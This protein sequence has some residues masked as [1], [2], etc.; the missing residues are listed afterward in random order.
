MSLPVRIA[1]RYSLARG[2]FLSFVTFI[3]AAGLALGTAVLVVVLSVMNGFERELADRVLGALP[4]AVILGRDGVDDWRELATAAREDPR[5]RAA[6]PISRGPALVA[7]GDRVRAVE[8]TGIEPAAEREVSILPGRML[9]GDMDALAAGEFGAVL[10]SR[11][12]AELEVGV[13]DRVTV[14]MPDPRVTLA[15]AFPRQKRMR[16]VGLFELGTELD[17]TGLYVHLADARRLLRIP[18]AAQGVRLRLHDLFQSGAVLRSLLARR[19]DPDLRGIDWRR[20]HGN[21]HEAIG[22]QKRIMFVLLSLLVAVA[23]FNVVAMLTMVVRNRRG[24]IA[25]LRTMG[26]LPGALVRVFFIQGSF[27][28]VAG[29]LAG[30]LLGVGVTLLLPTIAEGLTALLGRDLLAEYFVRELPVAI[31]VPDL[32]GIVLVALAI[33]LLTTWWPAH[34]ALAVDPAEELRHE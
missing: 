28:A 14:V 22:L 25:I 3:A 29:I 20:T 19:G 10:G 1:L 8:L 16:V 30:L 7:A 31:R 32:A 12:A 26:M 33:S 11:L 4:H 6:A 13:G 21:L 23:A 9:A 27:I 24:D 34:R 15:G 2:G 17:E 5:V 18:A